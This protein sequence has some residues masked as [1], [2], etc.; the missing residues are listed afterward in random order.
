VGIRIYG[1]AL[2][3]AA[4]EERRTMDQQQ[5][6][7]I[8][9][10][11]EQLTDSTRQAFQILA[12]RTVAWQESN[13]R[14]TQSFFQNVVEQLHSQAEGT[15]EAAQNLQE[16]GQRQQEAFETL[17]QEGTNV[18]AEFLNSA[19]SFYQEALRAATEAAQSNI[20]RGVQAT[21]QGVQA[22]SQAG[23]QAVEAANQ[24]GQQGAQAVRE[25]GEQGAQAADQSAR[26]GARASERSAQ[27]V[28]EAAQETAESQV[29]ATDAARR[30]AQEMGVDLSEIKGTGQDGQITVDD[31]RRKAQEG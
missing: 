10:A 22:T 5:T 15:R 9:R 8:E 1:E 11:T 25:A 19:L 31:V 18:Y 13:L 24:A 4:R 27:A 29:R 30:R 6:Q 20:Q 23:Q 14:F 3:Q 7:N 16:Q 17:S 28:G 2:R 12:D 21:Q 26:E